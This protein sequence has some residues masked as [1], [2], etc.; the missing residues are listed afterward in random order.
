[1]SEYAQSEILF[2][3]V[4][5]GRN[6]DFETGQISGS[7]LNRGSPSQLTMEY[8][9]LKSYSSEKIPNGENYE[10]TICNGGTLCC[11][12]KVL[13]R[14]KRQGYG[15]YHYRA[16]VFGGTRRFGYIYIG[17]EICGVIFCNGENLSNCTKRLPNIAGI[18]ELEYAEISG[19]FTTKDGFHMPITLVDQGKLT[20]ME[21]NKFEFHQNN[22][23]NNGTVIMTLRA[24]VDNVYT[25]AIFGRN[26]SEVKGS[27]SKASFFG[28]V[29]TSAL[30]CLTYWYFGH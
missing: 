7:V 6:R 29:P 16:A 27:A 15:N 30:V 23:S 24:P 2:V 10:S 19:N 28:F 25:F 13:V 4:P 8:D 5:I 11:R 14:T 1:M 3:R 12:F 22:N 26:Y 21:P 9:S 18:N 20:I 17:M